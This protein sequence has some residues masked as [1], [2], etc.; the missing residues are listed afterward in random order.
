MPTI[1]ATIRD[2]L[3]EATSQSGEPKYVPTARQRRDW[4]YL[5]SV[6][7][8]DV[9]IEWDGYRGVLLVPRAKVASLRK[10]DSIKIER[11]PVPVFYEKFLKPHE[12]SLKRRAGIS[13]NHWW[14]LTRHRTWQVQ[15]SPKLLSTYFGDRGS[16]AWDKGGHFV[17]VQGYGWLPKMRNRASVLAEPLAPQLFG[18]A[19]Q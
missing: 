18:S 1:A 19:Q 10:G 7:G 15:E 4:D 12:L 14:E 6:C 3:P 2:G 11:F 16:F 9:L 17:V 5:R 13:Q 8:F